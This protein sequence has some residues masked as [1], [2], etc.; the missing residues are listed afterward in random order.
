MIS[1]CIPY[2]KEAC[3]VAAESN[4][5]ELGTIENSGYSFEG[6]YPTKGC[7]VY[8]NGQFEGLVYYGEH[9][10]IAQMKEEPVS[11]QSRPKGYDCGN[12][13]YSCG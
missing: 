5:Y 8:V 3:A 7:Y 2:S 12:R 10:T 4:G 13:T 1:V 9:G 11:P 6:H